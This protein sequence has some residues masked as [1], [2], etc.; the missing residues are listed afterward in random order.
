M[1]IVGLGT[2]WS[3]A[4]FS[5]DAVSLA[6]FERISDGMTLGDV[7]AI[8]GNESRTDIWVG[9]AIYFRWEGCNKL[10]SVRIPQGAL[11]VQ[12]K[13]IANENSMIRQLK[14]VGDQITD[15]YYQLTTFNSSATPVTMNVP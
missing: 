5:E 7:R 6:N 13:E 9:D 10:I 8:L 15:M 4:Q 14:G 2:W 1:F 12:G 3:W 11:A